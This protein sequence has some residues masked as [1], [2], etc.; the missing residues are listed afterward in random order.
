[1]AVASAAVEL[2]LGRRGRVGM[3]SEI[4]G[5]GDRAGGCT[6]GGGARCWLELG[7][8]SAVSRRARL[9]RRTDIQT[10][11]DVPASPGTSSDVTS[12]DIR[13]VAVEALVRAAVQDSVPGSDLTLGVQL[14]A[15]EGPR[16]LDLLASASSACVCAV[17]A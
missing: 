12:D 15:F 10:F 2:R 16:L 7:M 9:E 11:S 13:A 5:D 14:L 1:V 8:K 4:G 6:S 3:G 17:V